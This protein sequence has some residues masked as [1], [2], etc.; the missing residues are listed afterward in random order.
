MSTF[1]F[2]HPRDGVLREG[3][4]GRTS[5]PKTTGWWGMV[6]LCAT[7]AML[8]ASFLGAYFF[9]RGNIDAF[10][11]EGGRYVP[12]TLPAIMTVVLLSSSATAWWAERG[13]ERGDSVRLRI[14]L[15]V[16]MLLGLAFLSLQAVEYSHRD[17]SWTTSAYDSLFITITGFHGAHVA[18]GLLM[19]AYVQLR[20]WLGHFDDEHHAAVSNV[21]LYWHFVDGVWVLLFAVLYLS[22]RLF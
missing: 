14:G 3:A 13:I 6:W 5:R 10:A 22:P 16:T 19:N 11:A 21:L 8:F 17:S 12:L 9:L 1:A 20:A 15:G 18:A 2:E 7:E 4:R